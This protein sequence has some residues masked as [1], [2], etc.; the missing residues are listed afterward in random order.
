MLLVPNI[1]VW[2]LSPVPRK[3]GSRIVAHAMSL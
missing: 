2:D 3:L 1:F